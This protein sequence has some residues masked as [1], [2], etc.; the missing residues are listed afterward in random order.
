MC[1][2]DQQFDQVAAIC[3]EI[4]SSKMKDYGA[5][6]RIM[7]TRSVTDQIFIKANRIRSI[8]IKG[9]SKVD[10]DIRSELIGIVNYGIIGLIQL[11]LGVSDDDD[12]G[13]EKA[14]QL[15]DEY[16]QKAKDLMMNKN[17]DYDEA[18]RS[19][20]MESYTDLILMKIN[21]TKKIEDNDGETLISEGIDANYLDMINY[22]VFGLIKME[23]CS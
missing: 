3:R 2:T 15:Y 10:E 19:M 13:R 12:I 17:H 4:Y 8:E 5:S 21:R 11:E 14:L 6:W 7:R 18:W 22:A 23:E 1:K 16:M 20:R 9:V